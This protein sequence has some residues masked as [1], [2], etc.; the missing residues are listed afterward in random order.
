MRKGETT[1]QSGHCVGGTDRCEVCGEQSDDVET[2]G[3]NREQVRIC[4]G[5]RDD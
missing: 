5:C 3:T 1:E 4:A 2:R